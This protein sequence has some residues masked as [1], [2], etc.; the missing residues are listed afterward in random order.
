VPRWLVVKAPQRG[1]TREASPVSRQIVKR[2]DI[3][4]QSCPYCNALFPHPKPNQQYCC[5]EHRRAYNA[6]KKQ[7]TRWANKAAESIRRLYVLKTK[8]PDMPI[9][10]LLAEIEGLAHSFQVP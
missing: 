5:E 6:L 7:G 10:P 3:I 4:L 1:M 9:D 2:K 8:Y